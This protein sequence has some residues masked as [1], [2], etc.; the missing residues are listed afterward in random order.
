MTREYTNRLLD[1][2][3]EKTLDA[4][5][6]IS[7]ILCYESEDWVKEFCLESF[8]GEIANFFEDLET[9]GEN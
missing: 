1:L 8:E 7:E 5:A 4:N 3:E 6:V 9:K 2:L